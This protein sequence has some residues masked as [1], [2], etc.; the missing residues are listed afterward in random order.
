M[1]A[2]R[3]VDE[4][5]GPQGED[6]PDGAALLSDARVRRAVHEPVAGELEDVLLERPGSTA[7][8][9]SIRQ[10]VRGRD[11]VPV[12][13][14]RGRARTHGEAAVSFVRLAIVISVSGSIAFDQDCID[15]G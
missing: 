11:S 8:G 2:V 5:V 7:S 1:A 4:V 14:R 3:A 10:Q 9:S 13:R 12:G 15:Q 6:R